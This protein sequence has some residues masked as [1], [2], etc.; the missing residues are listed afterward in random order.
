MTTT[1]FLLLCERAGEVREEGAG[2]CHRNRPPDEIPARGRGA[3]HEKLDPILRPLSWK[4]NLMVKCRLGYDGKT[5]LIPGVPE[6]ENQKEG[7]DALLKFKAW[8][9]KPKKRAGAR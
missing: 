5:I 3:A 9:V 6:A 2:R 4:E 1:F 8:A 7:L